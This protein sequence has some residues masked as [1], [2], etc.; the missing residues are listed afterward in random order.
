MGNK[1]Y[2]SPPKIIVFPPC[3]CEN[4]HLCIFPLKQEIKHWRWQ[5]VHLCTKLGNFTWFMH[6]YRWSNLLWFTRFRGTNLD[7]KFLVEDRNQ[8]IQPGFAPFLSFWICLFLTWISWVIY[9]CHVHISLYIFR[10]TASNLGLN[11]AAL[12]RQKSDFG[13]PRF[14]QQ[15]KTKCL[16]LFV[17]FRNPETQR[18]SSR[19]S[20][21]AIFGRQKSDISTHNSSRWSIFEHCIGVANN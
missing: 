19:L 6:F 11:A 15:Q 1:H 21:G 20:C 10:E 3:F 4:C 8:F 18:E 7:H 14:V 9:Y 16:G 5:N 13:T 2:F 17:A 12:G